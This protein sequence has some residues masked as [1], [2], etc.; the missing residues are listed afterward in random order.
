MKKIVLTLLFILIMCISLCACDADVDSGFQA[1]SPIMQ[2]QGER[3]S[4][5]DVSEKTSNSVTNDKQNKNDAETTLKEDALQERVDGTGDIGSGETYWVSGSN[6]NFRKS[7]S[8]EGE[9]ITQLKQGTEIVKMAEDGEWAYI[10]CG[11]IMGYVHMDYL[12]NYQPVNATEG[13][14]SIIVK[15][16]ERLLEL[17]QDEALLGSYSI[18]LGWEPE[19]HK[20]VEGDGKTPEGEYYVCV[21]NSNSSFYLSLGVSYPNKE[22]AAAALEDGRIDNATYKRIAD[23]I[24][25]GQCPDWYTSLGG[26]IMIHGCGGSSDWTAGCIAVDNDVM[27]IL[28]ECCSLGTKITILP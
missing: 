1:N 9:I 13:E 7:P 25:K 24:E 15:K 11:E 28:F 14:V 5:S 27:D 8:T 23:A 17:W 22:D 4:E 12:S 16:A 3:I 20:Q 18:G 10:C 19:G 26:E 6:V 2:I 21:R